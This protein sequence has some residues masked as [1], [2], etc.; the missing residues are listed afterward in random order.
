MKDRRLV[1]LLT[2]VGTVALS[3]VFPSGGVYLSHV[4]PNI[5][6]MLIILMYLGMGMTTDSSVLLSGLSRWRL[7]LF[8]QGCLFILA[9]LLSYGLF[10]A[11]S[12]KFGVEDS[13][14][15]LFIGTLP[16]TITSCILLTKQSGGNSVGAMYNATLSQLLGVFV[17]PL[18]LT[19]FLHARVGGTGSILV[20]IGSLMR[21][22]LIPLVVGQII[23]LKLSRVV[24]A[25]GKISDL[26][27]YYAIFVILYL[28]LAQVLS[29]GQN[30]GSL[31]SL[32]CTGVSSVLLLVTLLVLIWHMSGWLHFPKE[33]R[34]AITYTGTQKTLGMGIP[35]AVLYFSE[36]PIMASRATIVIITYYIASLFLSFIL[37]EA[38]VNKTYGVHKQ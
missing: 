37:V 4:F 11:L 33:D 36:N 26:V 32:V 6:T 21:K 38:L 14:G 13:V 12:L 19:L 2:L 34:V 8:V 28:N 29:S 27:I 9:P 35:L 3:F 5:Q 17:T 7:H 22:I 16:T 24:A 15:I 18:L 23:R 20:V 1:F 30:I 10:Q 31:T 25:L